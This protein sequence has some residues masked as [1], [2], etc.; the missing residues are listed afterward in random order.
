MSAI[1]DCYFT[2]SIQY[3]AFS[4][5]SLQVW[6]TVHRFKWSILM[7]ETL[8]NLSLQTSWNNSYCKQFISTIDSFMTVINF[9][10]GRDADVCT[11]RVPATRMSIGISVL[12]REWV[13]RSHR[14]S[15]YDSLSSINNEVNIWRQREKTSGQLGS[16]G[17]AVETGNQ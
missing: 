8:K 5:M 14:N 16:K 3:P 15:L 11:D 6:Q 9:S 7:T 2:S 12:D 10:W 13:T 17:E 1:L 4:L